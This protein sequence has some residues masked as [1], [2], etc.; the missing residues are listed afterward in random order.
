MFL[1]MLASSAAWWVSQKC[2]SAIHNSVPSLPCLQYYIFY[3]PW[4]SGETECLAFLSWCVSRQASDVSAEPANVMCIGDTSP[5]A[6][7][8][9]V[10]NWLYGPTSMQITV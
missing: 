7:S 8:S 3:G 5:E 10:Q 6:W 2:L 1:F 4:V 9:L